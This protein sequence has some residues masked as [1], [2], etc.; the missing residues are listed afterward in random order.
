[1]P[2]DK[3]LKSLLIVQLCNPPFGSLQ[4]TGAIL[5]L[6]DD[7]LLRLFDAVQRAKGEKPKPKN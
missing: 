5:G 2:L 3:R 7:Q 1:V 4:D 6:S